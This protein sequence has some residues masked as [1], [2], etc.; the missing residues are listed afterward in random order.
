MKT[1]TL[2]SFC[3]SFACL[4]G[5]C[6]IEARSA[7]APYEIAV[8]EPPPQPVSEARPNAPDASAIWISGYWHW[9]GLQY[10]WIP[11][12]W[13]IPRAGERWVAPHYVMRDGVYYYVPGGWRA[14]AP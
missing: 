13:E 6:V 12:H 3:T 5:G 8:A 10:A 2:A 11:G 1:A 14:A 4:A 7:T 9:S